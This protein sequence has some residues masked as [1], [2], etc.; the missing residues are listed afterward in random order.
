MG[1]L[2]KEGFMNQPS[3]PYRVG[4]AMWLLYVT[5]GIGLIRSIIEAKRFSHVIP[6]EFEIV[7]IFS[8]FGIMWFFIHMIGK[9]K[10]WAR[11][12]YIV[13]F[14]IGFPFSILPLQ[15][16]IAA[17]LLAGV[18]GLGQTALQIIALAFLFQKSSSDWFNKR[19][20]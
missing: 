12:T 13:L 4:T 8:V 18:L 16:S 19:S 3:I 9:G 14:V 11:Y 15:Q 10:N 2:E 7:I 1:T 5:L 20:T 17:N 6:I